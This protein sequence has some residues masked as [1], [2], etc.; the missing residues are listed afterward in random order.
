MINGE[1]TTQAVSTFDCVVIDEIFGVVDE[2][3]WHPH[4]IAAV[5]SQ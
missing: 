3:Y 4:D 2:I 1:E 5:A